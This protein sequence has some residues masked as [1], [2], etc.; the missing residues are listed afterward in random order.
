VKEREEQLSEQTEH[1]RAQYGD[2]LKNRTAF[3]AD[4]AVFDRQKVLWEREK[5]TFLQ[6]A[7]TQRVAVSVTESVGVRATATASTAVGTSA[8]AKSME[9][10]VTTAEERQVSKMVG[11]LEEG[12]L[13]PKSSP[14]LSAAESGECSTAVAKLIADTLTSSRFILA[15]I[16]YPD[17]ARPSRTNVRALHLLP[18]YRH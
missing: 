1:A 7:R 11:G 12:P 10:S 6:N 15:K 4:K 16:T 9:A 17:T 2:F 5:A 14:S 3:D 8:E 13:A 18:S